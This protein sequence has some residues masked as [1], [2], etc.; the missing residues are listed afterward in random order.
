[1][2]NDK[3]STSVYETII[4][5]ATGIFNFNEGTYMTLYSVHVHTQKKC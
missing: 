4:V 1:M 5:L 2:I 3:L